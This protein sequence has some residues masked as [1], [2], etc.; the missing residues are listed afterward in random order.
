MS[1]TGVEA[2]RTTG[3]AAQVVGRGVAVLAGAGAVLGGVAGTVDWPLVGTFFAA[4][5]GATAG[6]LVG[7]AAGLALAAPARRSSSSWL[8][9]GIAA[10][11]SAPASVL[12]ASAY[13]G[14][15]N[16]PRAMEVVLVVAAIL[17]GGAAGP[18]IA[19]GRPVVPGGRPAGPA[20]AQLV[21][22]FL[23]RGAAIGATLGGVTG[24]IVG[25]FAYLP[26]A[27]FAVVEGAL[28]GTVSGLVLACLAVGVRLVF[29]SNPLR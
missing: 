7:L 6:A 21:G 20:L 14:P 18:L 26:T 28:F 1:V 29:P 24:G 22:R 12:G 17:I 2:L 3:G 10:V 4:I 27:P 5:E 19:Y 23:G 15:V 16:V 13:D 25:V 11:V 8:A 9:R